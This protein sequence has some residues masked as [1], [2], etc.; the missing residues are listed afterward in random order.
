M[1]GGDGYGD[2]CYDFKRAT[3]KQK[4]LR[5]VERLKEG[6]EYVV[7]NAVQALGNHPTM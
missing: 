5:P 1:T 6:L 3:S 7:E 4:P 2:G